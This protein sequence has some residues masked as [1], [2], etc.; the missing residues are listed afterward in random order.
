M[1]C[2]VTDRGVGVEVHRA[3]CFLLAVVMSLDRLHGCTDFRQFLGLLV[4][5][6]QGDDQCFQSWR[7]STILQSDQPVRDRRS[8]RPGPRPSP[9]AATQG[10]VGGLELTNDRPPADVPVPEDR[11]GPG[12]GCSRRS[13]D[14][15]GERGG[16][17]QPSPAGGRF[18]ARG[19]VRSGPASRITRL[20]CLGV[21]SLALSATAASLPADWQ[22][23]Q[24]F[25]VVER[26]A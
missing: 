14:Q 24:T 19:R 23:V 20:L 17:Y 18:C 15:R 7:D 12:S 25:A 13:N 16:I 9:G 4:L 3:T 2:P 21:F 26:Q 1:P 11:H 22:H 8:H 5:R 10:R 6:V